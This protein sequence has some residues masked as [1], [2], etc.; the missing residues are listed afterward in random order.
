MVRKVPGFPLRELC[1]GFAVVG[2]PFG[3]IGVSWPTVGPALHRADAALGVVLAVSA[4]SYAGA[5]L[6]GGRLI[7]RFG[8]GILLQASAYVAAAGLAGMGLTRAWWGYLAGAAVVGFA[9][10]AL[11]TGL[12][13]EASAAA[14]VGISNL[15]HAFFAVGATLPPL[16]LAAFDA[17]GISW[18]VMYFVLAG[19]DMAAGWWFRGLRAPHPTVVG[20]P[21]PV[22][23]PTY[24][25]A[26]RGGLVV[27]LGVATF[28]FY[29]AMEGTSGQWSATLLK[30]RG[31]AGTA[32]S[33]WAG[34]FFA[35]FFVGRLLAAWFG[36]RLGSKR[37]LEVSAA[38]L[39]T[40]LTLLWWAPVPWLG[41]AALSINGMA[42]AAVFPTLITITPERV[43]SSRAPFVIGY[44]VA[45]AAVGG[46]IAP[47]V[48]SA[49]RDRSSAEVVVPVMVVCAIAIVL[50]ELTLR[51]VLAGD[52]TMATV[53]VDA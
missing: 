38:L 32:R 6:A 27:A 40:G 25:G 45:A 44:E 37:L 43:G 11:D 16:L 47:L 5:G 29:V 28:F 34:S 41:A 8:A 10:G 39:G 46:T 14:D 22:V 13:V 26:R 12:N 17:A 3:A 7:R 51:R 48:V 18:R 50:L 23:E 24:P 2:L 1:V 35:G 31:F 36:S 49:L 9:G 15:L 20:V 30:A 33:L 42:M 21:S 4:I 52:V 53:G 19:L